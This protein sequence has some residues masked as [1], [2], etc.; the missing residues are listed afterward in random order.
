MIH[1]VDETLRGMLRGG[2]LSGTDIEVS[3]EAPTRDWA[4]RR[5]VPTIDAYLYDIREDTARRHRGAVSVHDEQGAVYKRRQPPR[6][7]R[8]SYLVTAWTKRPEDEHRLLSAVLSTMLP[9]EHISP[10]ELT[11]SL[12]D[13]NLTV[14]MTTAAP[15][16]E[17]RSLADIWSALGGEL[18]PSLDVVVVAP[19]PAVREYDVGP[20]V[21]EGLIRVNGHGDAPQDDG[22]LR[23]QERHLRRTTDSLVPYGLRNRNVRA[24]ARAAAGAAGPAGG[25]GRDGRAGA[26][27]ADGEDRKGTG[28]GR[29]GNGGSDDDRGGRGGRR[30][31]DDGK[32][33]RGGARKR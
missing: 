30:G 2:V 19:F 5:N 29:T 4:A 7:F 27:P 13:L 1:E 33:G 6:W 11:G 21:Q 16:L 10:S 24:G 17:S 23:H 22:E 31:N 9:R 14:P 3:F 18:K 28:G 26:G 25:A 32:G 8:L 15:P 20:L 12:A